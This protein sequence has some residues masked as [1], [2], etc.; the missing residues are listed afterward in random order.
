MASTNGRANAPLSEELFHEPYRF[1]FFQAVRLLER[2]ARGSGA[3]AHQPVGL[4]HPPQQE[5]VRFRAHNALSFPASPIH[6]LRSQADAPTAPPEMVVSFMGLTGATGVLPFHYTRLLIQRQRLKD[7]TLRDFFDLF[8][9]RTISLFYR[10]W[11]KHRIPVLYERSQVEDTEDVATRCLFSLVGRGT[12]GQRGR[13]LFDDSIFLFFAGHFAHYPRNA[14]ALGS[15]LRGYF[16]CEIAVEQMHGQWLYLDQEN[17]SQLPTALRGS[18]RYAELG[19]DAR[20]GDRVWDLQSKFRLRVGPLAF[21]LYRRLL[22]DGDMLRPLAQLTRAYVG[23][24]LDFDVQLVLQRD[25]IPHCQLPGAPA[26]D[27]PRLGWNTWLFSQPSPRD[28]DDAVFFLG[29]V[30]FSS[31]ARW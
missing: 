4:D 7:H 28:V 24:D 16:R 2:L 12:A 3:S 25:D 22:P 30:T 10:A 17:R 8:N 5:V 9:H 31:H 6:E 21:S 18:G 11:E 27:C 20:L 23:S 19:V 13:H 15:I 14:S 1:D 26:A 29:D